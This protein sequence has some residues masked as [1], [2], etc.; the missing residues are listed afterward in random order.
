MEIHIARPAGICYGV[1]R[2]L[3][4]AREAVL[5]AGGQPVASIGALIHN[6]QVVEELSREGVK[7]VPDLAAIDTGTL[8][9]RSHGM[10]P[11][12]IEAASDKG[13]T[14]VD[15][16]CP[17]VARAQNAAR[18][19]AEAGFFVIIVG[20][21]EHPEVK[22]ILAR[23]GTEALVVTGPEDLDQQPLPDKIGLVV[24]TTQTAEVLEAVVTALRARK[25]AE[26]RVVNTIC[27][28]TSR[29]QQAARSLAHEVDVM[30]VVGGHNSS[31]T[32]RLT[33]VAR[34][35]NPRTWQVESPE[36]LRGEWFEAAPA[37]GVTAGASTPESQLQQVVA[38]IESISSP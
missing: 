20:E 26:L 27:G 5:S 6:P 24:Q 37:V 23:G 21:P 11:D 17:Y 31:N 25:P 38:K 3:R 7:A 33:E 29:R 9:I 10:A 32:S 13:L 14:I 15:A 4:L 18:E 35:V 36:E 2:A 8:V 30:I 22:G 1:G 34:L 12:I 16:T 19:L 28:A